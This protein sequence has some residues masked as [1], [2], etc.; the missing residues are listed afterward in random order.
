LAGVLVGVTIAPGT[1]VAAVVVVTVVHASCAPDDCCVLAYK[2]VV[3]IREVP[4]SISKSASTLIIT[5]PDVRRARSSCTL[6]CCR[7][8]GSGWSLWPGSTEFFLIVKKLLDRPANLHPSP[9]PGAAFSSIL[10]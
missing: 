3:T 6:K 1:E 9:S 10:I 4:N 8:V 2:L 7:E 5:R